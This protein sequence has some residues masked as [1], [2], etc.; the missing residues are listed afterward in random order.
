MRH[1]L[2]ALALVAMAIPAGAAKDKGVVVHLTTSTGADAGTVTFSPSKSGHL[3]AKF[4]LKG[5][6]SGVHG[7]H[8]HAMPACDGPRLQVRRPTYGRAGDASAF[9]PDH[10]AGRRDAVAL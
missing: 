10:L 5:I 6:D 3:E 9:E 2:L 7:F 4:A 8:I 1:S